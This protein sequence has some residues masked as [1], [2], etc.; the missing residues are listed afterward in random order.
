MREANENNHSKNDWIAGKLKYFVDRWEKITSDQEILDTIAGLKI[1]FKT[2]P[3]QTKNNCLQYVFSPNEKQLLDTEIC[4]LVNLGVLEESKNESIE[5]LSPIFQKIKPD[6]TCRMILNLKSLNK[7]IV[8]QHFKMET[9]SS[10][11]KIVR[12]NMFFAS[13]D[14]KDAYYT[15]NV[16]PKFRKFLKFSWNSKIYKYTVAPN[17]LAC[18]PRKFTK[19]MK[20]VLAKLREQSYIVTNYKIR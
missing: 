3:L 16:N 1:S 5:F 10:I 13:V 18:V 14:L 7:F 11:L 4:R 2:R 20:P 12:P 9:I 6:G 8:Y 17:G 19:I 15:V